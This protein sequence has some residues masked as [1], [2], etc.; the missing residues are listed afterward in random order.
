M[1]GLINLFPQYYQQTLDKIISIQSA[2]LDL[3]VPN[4]SL[5][6]AGIVSLADLSTIA[7]RTALTGDA[8]LLDA[9]ILCPGL[10]LQQRATEVHGNEYPAVAAMTTGYAFRVENPATVYYLQ[11]VGRTGQLTTLSVTSIKNRTRAQRGMAK[12]FSGYTANPMVVIP[13]F[14]AV[15]GTLTTL[16]LLILTEDV[17]GLV[18]IL[19]LML[20][21]LIHIFLIRNRN[22]EGW[23][24]AK[25]PGVNGDLLVLLSQDRWVRIRGRVDDLKAVTSGNW[26]REMNAVESALAGFATILVYFTAALASN[27]KQTGKI[28]LTILLIS[29]AGL[30]GVVNMSTR[31]MQMHG[32]IIK[33]DGPRKEYTRRLDLAKELVKES[34]RTDWALRLGMINTASQVQD[35]QPDEKAMEASEVIM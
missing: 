30:L 9:F 5:D 7:H 34:G 33:V 25:E 16:V 15:G 35:V 22:H 6:L 3:K 20:S 26:L 29:S 8:T 1:A 24:G 17:W 31:V 23:K 13:Y 18:V 27:A 12:L 11:Q 19:L 2:M 14:L 4:I 28:L 10:H 32:N 21:R